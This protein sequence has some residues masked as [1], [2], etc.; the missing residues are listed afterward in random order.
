MAFPATESN[1]LSSTSAD[2]TTVSW[3]STDNGVVGIPPKKVIEGYERWR[4]PPLW[5]QHLSLA[6]GLANRVCSGSG[7]PVSARMA[8]GRIWFPDYEGVAVLDPRV[9]V[10]KSQTPSVWVETVLVE[11]KPLKIP[12]FGELEMPSSARRFEFDY[13]APDAASPHNV[14][15]RYKLEGMDTDWVE[16]GPERAAY[17]SQLK[18]GQY[19]FRV[20][21]GGSD[22]QW[23]GTDEA[24]Y[25]RVVP[26]L[27]ER[28][29]DTSAAWRAADLS[30]GRRLCFESTAQTQAPNGTL[31]DA[32]SPGK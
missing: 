22:G 28:A 6:E 20:M 24:V 32:A 21:V 31:G 19:Q 8:D 23:H 9:V 17:Y 4:S 2:G 5:C 18:P 15:F 7:Q 29:M 27:W 3:L 25:L 14:W 11:G 16:A 26:R 10:T 1:P 12:R 13:T 30:H